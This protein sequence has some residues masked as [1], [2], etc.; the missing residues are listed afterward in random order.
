ME[1]LLDLHRRAAAEFDRRMAA[2]G[3]DQWEAPT[4]CTDWNVRALVRHLVYENVWVADLMAGATVAEVGDRYEGDLLGDDPKS[5]WQDALR[6]ALEE[7][8]VPGA[9]E[10]TVH[11]SYGDERASE[12]LAQLTLDHA[13]HGWDLARAIGADDALDAELVEHLW[14]VWSPRS[15]MIGG[16]GVFAPPVDVAPGADSQTRLLGLLGRRR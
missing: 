12:Y 14:T 2:I 8:S 16:S 9:L 6:T 5:A 1:D 15:E 10:R 13:V 7:L 3:D 11:L 4:P